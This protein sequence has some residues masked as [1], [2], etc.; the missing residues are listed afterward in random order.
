MSALPN[1]RIKV[2]VGHG[3][4]AHQSDPALVASVVLEFIAP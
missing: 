2:L 3:H 1:A 4:I